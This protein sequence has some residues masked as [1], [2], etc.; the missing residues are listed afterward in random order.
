MTDR[1][2]IKLRKQRLNENYSHSLPELKPI[3]AEASIEITEKKEQ[4][5]E[6]QPTAKFPNER[7]LF[8]RATHVEE[9]RGMDRA[10][11]GSL[12]VRAM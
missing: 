1:A 7:P 4:A 3:T 8:S 2:R 6:R 12:I 9:G 11:D 5:V 10:T